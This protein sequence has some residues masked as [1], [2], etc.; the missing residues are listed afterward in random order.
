[1]RSEAKLLER[2]AS[3]V[4][5]VGLGEGVAKATRCALRVGFV[6]KLCLVMPVR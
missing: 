4:G 1:M 6:T 3:R 2:Q 5:V